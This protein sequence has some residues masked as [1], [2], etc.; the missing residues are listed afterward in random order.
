MKLLIAIQCVLFSLALTITSFAGPAKNKMIPAVPGEL[1]VK[2]VSEPN[3]KSGMTFERIAQDLRQSFVSKSTVQVRHLQTTER[4]AVLKFNDAE[5]KSA[6]NALK[7]DSRVAYAE[8]NFIYHVVGTEPAEITPNDEKYAGLWGMKNVGQADATGQIGKAGADIHVSPVW[9][10]G[11]TGSRKI[12]VA[13]ID[14]GI[15]YNHEDLKDNVD[16]SLGFNFVDNKP[17]AMDDNNHGSHCAGTIGGMGNNN[18]GVTGVN[19]NVTM[20]PVKFLSA[21]GGG[22]LDAA[23]QSIQWAT[24]QKVDVMSNSWGGGGYSQALYD[25]ISDAEKQGIVFIAAAG[26]DGNNNDTTDTYPANYDLPN[27]IAVA[28]TDNRD[29]IASF[30]NYGTAKVHVAAPGVKILSTVKNGGYDTFSGTSMATP[31]VAGI[32]ALMLSVNPS[33]SYAQIK[34]TLIRTS[35][36]VRGLSRKVKAGGRVNVY[37]AIHGIEPVDSSPNEADWKDFSYS[38][39]SPHPYEDSKTYSYST[40]VPNARFVRVVFETIDTEAGYDI[41]SIKDAKGQE[42]ESISGKAANYASDYIEGSKVSITLTTDSSSSRTGF[43]VAKL[44]VIY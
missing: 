31:H 29:Q 35:D 44:Q 6:I 12:K 22:T 20:I 8:P 42:A 18:L 3:Q 15:N 34:D 9:A 24:K 40:E 28:A 36:K 38:V 7:N 11:I 2:L 33:L 13:I 32:A 41:I 37:N 23:L 27:V 1:V 10:E 16:A 14:T 39:E 17:D 26:N 19:W 25:A 4:Y 30:S 5:M 21:T 43:K